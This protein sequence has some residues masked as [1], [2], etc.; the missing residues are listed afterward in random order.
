MR[1]KGT[2]SEISSDPSYKEGNVRFTTIP[3]KPLLGEGFC[4][5]SYKYSGKLSA[6]KWRECTLA[7]RVHSTL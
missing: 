5:Y 1:F 3:L 7:R 4:R 6:K 2:V